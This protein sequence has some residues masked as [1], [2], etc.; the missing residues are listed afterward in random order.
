MDHLTVTTRN[1]AAHLF[2]FVPTHAASHRPEHPPLKGGSCDAALCGGEVG[3]R[4][5]TMEKE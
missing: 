1:N 3:D 4:S 2:R 5:R